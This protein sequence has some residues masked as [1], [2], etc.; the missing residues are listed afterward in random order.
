MDE[1]EDPRQAELLDAYLAALQ[2][3]GRPDRGA[4]LAACPGL[5]S[6]LDCLERLEGLAPDPVGPSPSP[7]DVPRDFGGFEILG[8]IGRGG[9]GVVYRARQKALDRVVALKMILGSQLASADHVRRFQTEARAAARLRHPNIVP[10]HEVGEHCGQHYFAME[11]IEGESLAAR[12]ARGP[13]EIAE[14]V[15]IVAAVARAVAHLHREGLIH[16]DLKPG[17]ILLDWDGRP[18]VTDFG[19]AKMLT[20]D[21]RQTASG[22]I[23]GTPNYMSPEQAACRHDDVGPASDVYSLGA[24]LYEI[25]T[26]R[27][28]FREQTPLETLLQVIDREPQ[29]PRRIN[30]RVPRGLELICLRCLAKSPDGRYA[31][32][33]ELADDLERFLCGE[34]LTVRP[35]TVLQRITQWSRRKPALASRLIAFVLFYAVET[36]TYARG[37]VTAEFHT[38][39]SLI[40]L[41]WTAGSLVCQRLL[42]VRRWATYAQYLWGTLDVVMLLAIMLKADGVA[43]RLVVAFP[44]LIAGAALWF[45]VRY[46]WFMTALALAAYG[47]L[48]VDFYHWRPELQMQFDTAIDRHV[49]FAVALLVMCTII[50]YLVLRIRVLSSFYRSSRTSHRPDASE[51]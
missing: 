17:N 18:Y 31:S 35:P 43:S 10:I 20:S 25:L 47:V 41:A 44:L 2:A 32:A 50:S 8:E 19:L 9:M 27:P 26:G 30:R 29:L 49:L 16:R 46:V 6:V 39:V 5:G 1:P 7:P 48:V 36:M 37:G 42:E 34:T 28:P 15:Q 23:T 4:L 45:H 40:L 22:V 51:E 24:I 13:L 3:G 21:S 38:D 11:Y 12:L 14:G 33:D